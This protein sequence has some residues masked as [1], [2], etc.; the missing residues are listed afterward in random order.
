MSAQT[1]YL[2]KKD[3]PRKTIP[4][5]ELFIASEALLSRGDMEV[6]VDGVGGTGTILSNE[7]KDV[8]HVSFQAVDKEKERPAVEKKAPLAD[9]VK[10][11]GK[12]IAS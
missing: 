3:D 11:V 4:L 12:K 2:R 5:G 10:E 1:I 6:Y 8:P 7:P 9:K